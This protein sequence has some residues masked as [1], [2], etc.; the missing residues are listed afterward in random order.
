MFRGY[1]HHAF[2]SDVLGENSEVYEA[3]VNLFGSLHDR[4]CELY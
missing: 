2:S 4:A 3:D 1:F